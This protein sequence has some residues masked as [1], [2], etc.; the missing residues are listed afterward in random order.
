MKGFIFSEFL[1]LAEE[2]FGYAFVDKMVEETSSSGVYTSISTYQV[3]ELVEMVVYISKEKNIPVP[4]L[5][6]AFGHFLFPRFVKS[7]PLFF[8]ENQHLFGFLGILHEIIHVEVQKLYPGALT[9]TVVLSDNGEKMVLS[10]ESPRKLAYFAKGMLE[11]A[12]VYFNEDVKVE[13]VMLKEDGS[14]VDF[15]LIKQ[16]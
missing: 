1:E 3:E 7:F 11:A 10:Y 13:M 4:D 12:I 2:K 16:S 8:D 5:L 6:V 14:K 9:P 15:N